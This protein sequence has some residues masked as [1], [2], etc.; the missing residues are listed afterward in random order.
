MHSSCAAQAFADEGSA[1]CCSVFQHCIYVGSP[2]YYTIKPFA[3]PSASLLWECQ[4]VTSVCFLS[5]L[6]NECDNQLYIVMV[7]LST[8]LPKQGSVFFNYIRWQVSF[9]LFLLRLGNVHIYFPLYTHRHSDTQVNY[10]DSQSVFLFLISFHKSCW[11][12]AAACLTQSLQSGSAGFEG[13][14][15]S[16]EIRPCLGLFCVCFS[17][18]S[19]RAKV[20][21]TADHCT[22][23]RRSQCLTPHHLETVARSLTWESNCSLIQYV[24][25]APGQDGSLLHVCDLGPVHFMSVLYVQ[26]QKTWSSILVVAYVL[27]HKLHFHKCNLTILMQEMTKLTFS[28]SVVADCL[29][30]TLLINSMVF[31]SL[32]LKGHSTNFT[33]EVQFTAQE[34]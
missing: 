32:L 24:R 11:N 33:H 7:H 18:I 12:G 29:S 20:Q 3:S 25:W 28:S 13:M 15:R 22:T 23:T 10:H 19:L 26:S 9:F 1:T 5:F 2:Q 34:K 4:N 16:L 27:S 8:A 14:D 30:A 21:G 6:S 31:G 17:F